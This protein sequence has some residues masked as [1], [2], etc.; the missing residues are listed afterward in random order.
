MRE[1]G[2]LRWVRRTAMRQF[3]KRVLRTDSRMRLP[4]GGTIILPRRSR[5]GSE[6]FV[7]DA[8]MDWGS[9]ALFSRFADRNADA[10]DVGS[11]IGYYAAYLAP[12]VRH[13][14][15]FEPDQRNL[16]AL[17]VNAALSSKITVVEKAVSDRSGTVCF[18]ETAQSERSGVSQDGRE[19]PAITV[20]D[21]AAETGARPTLIKIDVEGH[22]L[23]VVRGAKRVM[24]EMQPLILA[25]FN[26][27]E[28][29]A[30]D[31]DALFGLCQERQYS[32]WSLVWGDRQPLIARHR[33]E[34]VRVDRTLL[35]TVRTKMLLLVPQRLEAKFA[36]LE[37]RRVESGG[38]SGGVPAPLI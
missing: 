31:V 5:S 12:L 38:R 10:F 32:V 27:N 14:Y 22:D 20:D 29:S 11:H 25:E 3:Q 4:T 9:E 36:E 26:L 7:S 21:F 15:A 19:V 6:A 33:T 37:R 28:T 2:V 17:R 18:A 30:N 16:P 24:A 1:V 34:L 23:A 8:N 13:V 35:E